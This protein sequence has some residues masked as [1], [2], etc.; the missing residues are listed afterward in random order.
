MSIRLHVIISTFNHLISLISYYFLSSHSTFSFCLKGEFSSIHGRE[1]S[2]CLIYDLILKGHIIC[3]AFG[4]LRVP[5]ATSNC[6]DPS[7][8]FDSDTADNLMLANFQSEYMATSNCDISNGDP[9]EAFDSDTADD[10]ILAH[11]HS[12]HM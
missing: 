7:E 4:E 3:S 12:E 2:H 11:F 10:L 6:G 9:K 8:A 1:L 5:S